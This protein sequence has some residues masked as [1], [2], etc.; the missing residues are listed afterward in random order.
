MNAF[1]ENLDTAQT[2]CNM[3]GYSNHGGLTTSSPKD[4]LVIRNSKAV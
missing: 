3:Y 2:A 4:I 1:R